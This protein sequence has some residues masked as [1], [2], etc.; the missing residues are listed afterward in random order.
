[1]SARVEES[2]L[3]RL[4]QDLY[5]GHNVFLTG[6]SIQ[7]RAQLL[8]QLL[9]PNIHKRFLPE[10]EQFLWV[11]IDCARLPANTSLTLFWKSALHPTL[12]QQNLP[13]SLKPFLQATLNS[14]FLDLFDLETYF[15]KLS[16]EQRVQVLLVDNLEMLLKWPKETISSTLSSLR[17]F[18]SRAG[19]RAIIS[20][21]KGIETLN[22]QTALLN[23]YGSPFFNIYLERRL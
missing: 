12:E 23:Q 17:S 13:R 2:L 6:G 22:Q 4:Y 1:M 20:S 3:S 14:S 8:Q 11:Y 18:S 5:S 19:L 21:S 7:Q 9:D 15:L 10:P 16:D